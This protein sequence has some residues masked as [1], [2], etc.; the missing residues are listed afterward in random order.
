MCVT[1]AQLVDECLNG[2]FAGELDV[3]DKGGEETPLLESSND[4]GRFVMRVNLLAVGTNNLKKKGHIV[5]DLIVGSATIEGAGAKS[6]DGG[7]LGWDGG[8]VR[9]G[10]AE[11]S[12]DGIVDYIGR[13]GD[14]RYCESWATGQH[15]LETVVLCHCGLY[16][17]RR[18]WFPSRS[19]RS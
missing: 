13:G 12:R 11:R 9:D 17:S 4:G 3:V 7:C 8:A 16:L 1:T 2:F 15:A 14:D 18:D 5:E 6:V 10:A 19:T